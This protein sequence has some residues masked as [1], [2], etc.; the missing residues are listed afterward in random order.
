[1]SHNALMISLSGSMTSLFADPGPFAMKVRVTALIHVVLDI[2]VAPV[3]HRLREKL[4]LPGIF[5]KKSRGI[6]RGPRN[7]GGR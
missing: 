1:M 5:V 4:Q 6:C 3:L 7:G 2:L